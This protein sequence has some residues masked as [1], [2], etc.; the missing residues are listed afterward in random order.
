MRK[1]FMELRSAPAPAAPAHRFQAPP[2]S[3]TRDA[4]GLSQRD[5]L[6]IQTQT[7]CPQSMSS[8]H[9][10]LHIPSSPGARGHWR[11]LLSLCC[12]LIHRA[13]R[14]P[15]GSRVPQL[16]CDAPVT[17]PL[18]SSCCVCGQGHGGAVMPP[19]G[20]LSPDTGTRIR[21]FLLHGLGQSEPGREVK[22]GPQGRKPR[23]QG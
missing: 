10:R 6:Q 16:G 14:P 9:A 3:H 20:Q 17:G 5:L 22:S 1:G 18:F 11:P 21:G 13:A 15:R 12:T 7:S 23:L 2:W 19:R 4:G 8:W